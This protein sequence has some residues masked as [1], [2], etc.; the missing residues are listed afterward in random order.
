MLVNK[1]AG[2]TY[3]DLNQYYIFPWILE[4]YSEHYLDIMNPK[5]YRD[6]KKPM[7]ALRP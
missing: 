7:G 6:L 5:T 3:C 4:N 1:Y 2:R